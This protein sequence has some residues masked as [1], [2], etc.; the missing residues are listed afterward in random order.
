MFSEADWRLGNGGVSEDL[1]EQK[2]SSLLAFTHANSLRQ[3]VFDDRAM[4]VG[5]TPLNSVVVNG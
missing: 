5:Q 1:K 4:D 2:D 3:N